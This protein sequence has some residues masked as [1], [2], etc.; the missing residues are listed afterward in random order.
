MIPSVQPDRQGKHKCSHR[1]GYDDARQYKSCRDRIDI[2]C[3]LLN[4]IHHDRRF[5]PGN[6]ALQRQKQ[7]HGGIH[8][9]QSDDFLNQILLQ[10]QIGKSDPEQDHRNR[11]F[12][13]IL[14]QIHN[15]HIS[16]LPFG[17]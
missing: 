2:S 1:Y 8:D 16:S 10:K 11:F 4:T 14:Y 15:I 13:I 3:H 5:P 6:I 9:V 12:I 7:I 17:T